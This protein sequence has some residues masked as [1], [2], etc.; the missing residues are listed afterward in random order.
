MLYRE[1]P[2]LWNDL[3]EV[4]RMPNKVSELFNRTQTL[5]DIEKQIKEGVQL[6]FF[7]GN[8]L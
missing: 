6:K 5:Y 4:Q 8:L 1:F 7:P 2:N 3:M